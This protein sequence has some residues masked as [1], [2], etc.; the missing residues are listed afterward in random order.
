MHKWL[1]NQ[2][3]RSHECMYADA[4]DGGRGGGGEGTMTT[5]TAA[6]MVNGTFT[7]LLLVHG[8]NVQLD[9][10]PQSTKSGATFRENLLAVRYMVYA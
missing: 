7:H 1:A 4:C 3:Q 5:S 10:T 2:M 9:C 8:D 6:A